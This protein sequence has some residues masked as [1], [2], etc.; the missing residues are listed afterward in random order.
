MVRWAASGKLTAGNPFVRFGP[1]K[2]RV[3]E[4][5]AARLQARISEGV[6]GVGPGLLIA[7][8]L[9]KADPKTGAATGEA[10]AVVP[11]RPVAGQPRTFEGDA[12]ALAIGPHVVRLDVPEL[13]EA[14][15]L[16]PAENAKAP[17]A[18]L[19][20][21]ARDTSE[22]VE[23]AAARDPL[24][25][26]ATATGG[27]VFA[28]HEAAALAPLLRARTRETVRTE[29]TPLWDQPAALILF[30]GIVTVEWV[31]RKRVGLP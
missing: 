23:L 10:V 3:E 27:K 13:A 12:P 26:L 18:A 21:V 16:D 24:E 29:E 25:R 7:A 4:G 5:D 6:A 1:V 9:F 17:E 30:L 31:A 8:R 15:R 11:L 28:D 22:R 20:V 2:P 14:L 19:E